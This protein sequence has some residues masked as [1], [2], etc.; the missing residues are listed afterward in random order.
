MSDEPKVRRWLR[1]ADRHG[2][3]VRAARA[4]RR[5]TPGAEQVALP[6]ADRPSDRVAR[7]IAQAG[8]DQPSAARELGLAAVQVW[9][10]LSRP[11]V[12]GGEVTILFTD[13][14]GFSGWA[15]EAGDDAVLR[16]LR[17][18][19]D[20]TTAVVGRR[21]GKVVKS[22]GD[23]VMAVF[24]ETGAAIEAAAEAC[25]AVSAITLDGYRPQLRTGLHTGRPRRVGRDYLGVDVNVAARVAAAAAGGEV[26][27]SG[28]ALAKVDSERYVV[29]RRRRFRAKG[30]PKDLDVYSV[31][32]RHA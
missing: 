30:T 20:V 18:V 24:A 17:E 27:V 28:P 12:A 7:L 26:L 22:L 25:T 23:G 1:D 14:V 5:L 6:S 19:G 29:R 4:L 13:L 16:L 21:G 15:L 2:A 8:G 3:A 11:G 10:A 32:P 31:V 9:Q